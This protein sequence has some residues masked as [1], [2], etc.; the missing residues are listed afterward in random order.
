MRSIKTVEL[1]FFSGLRTVQ[2]CCENPPTALT[3]ISLLHS[4]R[5]RT[6][7]PFLFLVC[8]SYIFFSAPAQTASAYIDYRKLTLIL[9]EENAPLL[10]LCKRNTLSQTHLLS[11]YACLQNAR[12]HFVSTIST[13]V[14]PHGTHHPRNFSS[15]RSNEQRTASKI[16]TSAYTNV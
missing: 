6:L 5:L 11:T 16:R 10:M 8:P 15:F 7:S 9:T 14:L 4:L 1:Q 2:K 12:V 13:L 3:F